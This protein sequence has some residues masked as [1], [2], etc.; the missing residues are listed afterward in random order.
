LQSSEKSLLV[1]KLPYTTAAAADIARPLRELGEVAIWESSRSSPKDKTFS[2]H[3]SNRYSYICALPRFE[4]RVQN[5][6]LVRKGRESEAAEFEPLTGEPLSQLE[7]VL[8]QLGAIGDTEENDT[9]PPFTRGVIGFISYDCVR[10][11]EKLP[12]VQA[13]DRAPDAFF[14]VVDSLIV[15]DHLEKQTIVICSL[16]PALPFRAAETDRLRRIEILQQALE[17]TNVSAPEQQV[18]LFEHELPYRLALEKTEFVKRVA[19]ARE[20]IAAGDI[21]QVVLA[22]TLT[23]DRTFNPFDAYATLK[24]VN[25]SPYHFQ[26][27]CGEHA[28]VGASP[29]AMLQSVKADGRMV[30]LTR[31][32]AGTYPR[33]QA[34]DGALQL[35][36]KERAEHIM[37]IDLARN[38]LGRVATLGSVEASDLFAVERYRH[39]DHLVSEVRAVLRP[40]VTPFDALRASFPIGTLAGAP[41]IRAME[42]IS[43]LEGPSR[44]VF[45]GAVLMRGANG[46][47]DA[48]VA[49]RCLH[50]G[51]TNTEI[52]VGAG[53]VYDSLPEREFEECLWKARPLLQTLKQLE[54]E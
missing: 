26:L 11:F 8:D 4:L 43:E 10:Y 37:L 50:F 1:R 39:L 36:E 14:L 23:I 20:Y 53:I 21:F 2:R 18:A 31:P 54:A 27:S 41:K 13:G 46:F 24:R 42:I 12:G 3:A 16:D 52:R 9:L 40:E 33:E 15:I 19:R 7:D 51:K 44:G 5:G 32:V 38:D 30:A 22:N 48:C 25:P 49:I 6:L 34:G 35:D 29:E 17:E 47:L 45:G 28:I